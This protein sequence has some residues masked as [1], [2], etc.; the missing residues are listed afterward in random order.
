MNPKLIELAERRKTL[1]A[2][3]ATQRAELSQALAPWREAL[4]VANQGWVAVRYIR[5]HA[6]LFAGAA[7]FVA[8]FGPWRAAKW[9]R[10]GWLVWNMARLMKRILPIFSAVF[11]GCRPLSTPNWETQISRIAAIGFN[12]AGRRLH[13]FF[14]PGDFRPPPSNQ[15][16]PPP[17]CRM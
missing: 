12:L 6:A 14:F 17:G 1:V 7:A 5:S 10:R 4:A 9:L 8:P 13:N 16:S 3:A 11:P 15:Q 2:R